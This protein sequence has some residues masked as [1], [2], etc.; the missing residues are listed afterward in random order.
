MSQPETIEQTVLQV[1]SEV[2]RKP[3]DELRRQPVLAAYKWDSLSSLEALAQLESL[4]GVSL[5]L[6]SY[7]QTRTVADLVRLVSP[8]AS[9][10]LAG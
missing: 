8:A 7:Q 4:L 5:D 10:T 3:I 1:L 2:L 6:R 9:S